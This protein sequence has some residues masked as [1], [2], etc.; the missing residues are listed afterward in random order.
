[1]ERAAA[2]LGWGRPKLLRFET[3]RRGRSLRMS[4][5]YS[6]STAGTKASNWR[7]CNS[8]ATFANA[9]GGRHSTTS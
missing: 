9:D 6:T 7:S 3:A 5:R 4:R 2:A 8:P 1:M